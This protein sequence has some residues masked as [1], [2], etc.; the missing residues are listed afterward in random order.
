MT[1]EEA[2]EAIKEAY[3]NSEYTDEIIKALDQEP[4]FLVKSDGT[5]EQIKNCNDC[6]LRKEWE[7]IGKMLSAILKKQ[8]EQEPC[9]DTVSRQAVIDAIF[10][11]CSITKLDIDFAK[12][13]LL[14]RT[15]KDLPSVTPQDPKTGHWYNPLSESGYFCTN[16][17]SNSDFMYPYC[18]HCGARMEGAE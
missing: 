15:I 14:R 5:F 1:K 17:E 16:C 9:E 3:G 7:K 13:L 10:A 2:I 8:T 11:E 6:L 4:K 18:P 12:V